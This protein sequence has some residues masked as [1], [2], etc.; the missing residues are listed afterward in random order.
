MKKLLVLSLLALSS[1]SFAGTCFKAI[2]PISQ[3]SKLPEQICVESYGLELIVP[4][5]PT[6]PFYQATVVTDLGVFVKKNVNFRRGITESFDVKVSKDIVLETRGACEGFYQSYVHINFKVDSKGI[7]EEH[8]L[9]VT[10]VTVSNQD[11]CHS[12]DKS[13]LIR[14][15][16]L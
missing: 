12:S 11:E 7:P 2:D 4:E 9:A 5:L 14:Y 16:N 6:L 15:E 10:G 13:I 1:L 8:T 3:K